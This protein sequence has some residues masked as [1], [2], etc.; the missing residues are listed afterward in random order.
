MRSIISHLHWCASSTQDGNS[1]IMEAKWLSVMNHIRNK[2]TGHHPLFPKCLHG[3]YDT[4]QDE[5]Q[6][7][8]AG[9]Y[10]YTILN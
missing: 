6:W 4:V 10:L 8:T 2:H 1:N 5:M 3:R 9:I 7:M